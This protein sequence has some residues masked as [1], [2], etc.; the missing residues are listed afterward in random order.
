[1]DASQQ[2]LTHS[3]EKNIDSR[4]KWSELDMRNEAM[5]IVTLSGKSTSSSQTLESE[6]RKSV[7]T[8]ATDNKHEMTQTYE[9]PE[10][11]SITKQIMVGVKSK[12]TSPGAVHVVPLDNLI[13][14]VETNTPTDEKQSHKRIQVLN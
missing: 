10:H 9:L 2:T 3:V 14:G 8:Q 11:Q 5:N 7:A 1:M 13:F 4:H 12:D 6:G